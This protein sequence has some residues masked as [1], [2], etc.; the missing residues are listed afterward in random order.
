[1]SAE[2]PESLVIQKSQTIKIRNKNLHGAH[3]V[4]I[5]VKEPHEL[6]QTPQATFTHT[7]QTP[8]ILT[9]VKV[10]IDT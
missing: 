4:D 1:M 9:Y 5:P 3:D 6:F 10:Y 7:H 2:P 8:E